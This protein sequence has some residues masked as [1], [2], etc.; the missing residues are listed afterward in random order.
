MKYLL[1]I[2]AIVTFT[3]CSLNSNS[4]SSPDDGSPNASS[5][6]P[7]NPSEP[8]ADKPREVRDESDI[9]AAEK[10]VGDW[11]HGEH[12]NSINLEIKS[13][14]TFS[15]RDFD[16]L[17]NRGETRTSAGVWTISGNTV[18]LV[19]KQF[20]GNTNAGGDKQRDLKGM[21]VGSVL[22]LNDLEFKRQEK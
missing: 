18:T 10:I 1:L 3:G 9:L 11:K 12:I 17:S 22:K 6:A 2:A 14:G 15:T 16:A 20:E 4:N 5:I 8:P 19:E 13:D 21:L 7:V